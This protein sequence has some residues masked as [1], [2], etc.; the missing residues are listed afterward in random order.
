MQPKISYVKSRDDV[1]WLKATWVAFLTALEGGR[2]AAETSRMD[3]TAGNESSSKWSSVTSLVSTVTSMLARK[4]S[5]TFERAASQT[6]VP[7]A[8]GINNSIKF[9]QESILSEET[10]ARVIAFCLDD[11]TNQNPNDSSEET[12]GEQKQ[13]ETCEHSLNPIDEEGLTEEPTGNS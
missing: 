9:K 2:G 11:E 8:A 12:L 6:E 5:A 3:S 4:K 13:D 1:S 7:A 10:S